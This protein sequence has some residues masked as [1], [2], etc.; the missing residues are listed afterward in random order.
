M[1]NDRILKALRREAV[2]CTPVWFMRQA[3]RYLP[4]YRALREKAGSFLK[5]SRTPELACEITLQPLR[6]FDLDAAILFADIL[7]LAD[8]MQ[9]EFDI[10]EGQGPVLAKPL[11]SEKDISALPALEL[12]KIDYIFETIKMIHSALKDRVPLIGFAGSPWTLAAYLVEGRGSKEFYF[13]RRMQYQNADLL[14]QLLSYLSQATASYV[15]EQIKAGVQVI[16]L[17]D[18]WS[19]LLDLAHYHLFS[20]AY[21]E[22]I[23]KKIKK[24]FPDVPIILYSKN[25]AMGLEARAALGVD[26]LGLDWTVDIGLAREKVGQRVALQGNLDPAVLYASAD[27]LR[28]EIKNNL[29]CFG[30]YPGHIFNLGHGMPADIPLE[31]VS[32]VIETVHGYKHF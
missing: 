2:D 21:I 15:S 7:T 14:H 16:M 20:L 23:A 24:D 3:G 25:G 6:R 30:N 4:E 27:I 29:L 8:A 13:L 9:L 1:K 31:N 28:R 12:S 17:F 10:V 26:A 32:V 22:K 11:R 5:L 19:G 18:T